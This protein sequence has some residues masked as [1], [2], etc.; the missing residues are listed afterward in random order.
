VGE[1]GREKQEAVSEST[2]EEES[3]KEREET[4]LGNGRRSQV[5]WLLIIPLDLT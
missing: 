1:N 4:D 2:V 3:K 5:G